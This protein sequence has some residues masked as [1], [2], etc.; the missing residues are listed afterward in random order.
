M[1]FNKIFIILS[2]V[3]V[4]SCTNGF[5]DLNK[6]PLAVNEGICNQLLLNSL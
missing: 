4:F 5:E 3:F 6:D 1:K 2:S